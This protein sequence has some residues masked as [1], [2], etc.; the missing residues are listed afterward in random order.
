M[1]TQH[2]DKDLELRRLLRRGDP[3]D[4]EEPLAAQDLARM[5]RVILSQADG[6]ESLTPRVDWRW[7]AVLVCVVV[8]AVV[9]WHLRRGP[10]E[11][12]VEPEIAGAREH[13]IAD[14]AVPLEAAPE[15]VADADHETEVPDSDEAFD[16]NADESIVVVASSDAADTGPAIDD[17]PPAETLQA[18]TLRFTTRRGTQIIWILDPELEL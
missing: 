6:G 1:K 18:R 13:S 5:R 8:L 4:G 16:E 15:E 7:A 12:A 2:S 14:D 10:D 9:G 17:D 3:V 11:P